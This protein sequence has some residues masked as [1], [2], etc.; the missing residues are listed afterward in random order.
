MT[1]EDKVAMSHAAFQQVSMSFYRCLKD[2]FSH[3][4]PGSIISIQMLEAYKE[5][6]P[7]SARVYIRGFYEERED[8]Q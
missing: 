1:K 7:K 5:V 8:N 2:N 4:M 3:V 6:V